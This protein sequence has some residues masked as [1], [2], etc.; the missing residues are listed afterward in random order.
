[1]CA[2][3]QM[4]KLCLTSSEE[5]HNKLNNIRINMWIVPKN[6]KLSAFA[7]DTVESSEDLSLLE[8]NLTS[9]LMW[10]S[11]PSPLPTWCRRWKRESWVRHLFGRI[12]KPCQH[13]YFEMR[14]MSSLEAIRANRLAQL[15][16]DRE[17]TTHGT[18][19]LTSAESSTRL[20][21]ADASSKTSKGTLASDSE[22]SLQTWKQEV[23]QRRGE[24]SQRQKSVHRTN[25]KGSLSWGTPRVGGQQCSKREIEQGNPKRRLECEVAIQEMK[26]WPTPTARDHKGAVS[27]DRTHEKLKKGERAHMGTLDGFTTYHESFGLPDQAKTNIK[28]KRPGQLNPGWVEQLMGLPTGWTGL[29]SWG[30]E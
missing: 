23:I 15:E 8:K 24:Y 28:K 7:P 29:G 5:I 17:Q 3:L 25:G 18:C 27:A 26:K 14:L 13:M 1:L 11:K 22:K 16:S 20:D 30:T 2:L 4:L 10:R 6:Y 12:L 9:S 19:G 21:H